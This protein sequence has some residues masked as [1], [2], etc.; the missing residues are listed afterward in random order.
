MKQL[1]IYFLIFALISAMM[2]AC[3]SRNIRSD[4]YSRAD[5]LTFLRQELKQLTDEVIADEKRIVQINEKRAE[6][7]QDYR[8]ERDGREL[9]RIKQEARELKQE[10]MQLRKNVRI[11]NSRIKYLTNNILRLENACAE[12]TFFET[13]E[14]GRRQPARDR[15]VLETEE[16][17]EVLDEDG[18]RVALLKLSNRYQGAR[19]FS[20]GAVEWVENQAKGPE[21]WESWWFWTIVGV[22][23]AGSVT[24]GTL[25]GLGYFDNPSTGSGSY[26]TVP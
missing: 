10:R 12:E 4:R 17:H 25:G 2:P 19:Q 22:S 13:D 6:L 9:R 8:D 23:V 20:E 3:S 14:D 24:L 15:N 26:Q 16:E 1:S 7:L 11:V 18:R 5:V 21:W